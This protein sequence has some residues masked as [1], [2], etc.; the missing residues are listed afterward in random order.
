[1]ANTGLRVTASDSPSNVET[2]ALTAQANSAPILI[3]NT[4]PEITGL[5]VERRA[6]GLRAAWKAVD[7]CNVIER[8][9][10]SLDGREWTLVDPAGKLSDSLALD[11]TLDLPEHSS[12]GACFGRSGDRRIR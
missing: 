6:N 5:A 11:Y 8:A 12:R 7:A 1:M 4:P 9:E 3:D 2:E 10:Y